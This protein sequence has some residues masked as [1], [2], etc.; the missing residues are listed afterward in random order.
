MHDLSSIEGLRKACQKQSMPIP[1]GVSRYST[2]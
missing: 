1:N 2:C